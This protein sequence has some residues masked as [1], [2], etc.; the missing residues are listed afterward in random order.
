MTLNVITN[1]RKA[2]AA[3]RREAES[4]FTLIEALLVLAVAAVAALGAWQLFS[5]ARENASE[6]ACVEQVGTLSSQVRKI[7]ATQATI[8]AGDIRA[9]VAAAGGFPAAMIN[10]ANYVNCFNGAVALTGAGTT[11]TIQF[12]GI[13]ADVCG[14][15]GSTNHG[16]GSLTGAVALAIN[17]NNIA[18]PATVAAATAACNQASNSLSWTFPKQ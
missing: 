9:E 7:Y 6:Q 17:G 1:L 11:Y 4:G 16:G 10:G 5:D 18:L 12:S 14:R 2:R 8:P 3:R 15:M 13:A